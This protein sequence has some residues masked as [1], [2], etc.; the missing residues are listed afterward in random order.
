MYSRAAQQSAEHL[1]PVTG[2]GR[3]YEQPAVAPNTSNRGCHVTADSDTAAQNVGGGVFGRLVAKCY[4][5][6]S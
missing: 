5:G 4:L 1:T 3:Y 6:I 2:V